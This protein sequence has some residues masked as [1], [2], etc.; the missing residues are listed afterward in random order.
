MCV[1]HFYGEANGFKGYH[2]NFQTPKPHILKISRKLCF[3]GL[4][5]LLW[6]DDNLKESLKI[7]TSC[8]WEIHQAI[9]FN[10]SHH[11]EP[12]EQGLKIIQNLDHITIYHLI[13]GNKLLVN[14]GV[15]KKHH[16]K[17]WFS[18]I[19]EWRNFPISCLDPWPCYWLVVFRPTPLKNDRVKVS[20][21][22][23]IPNS[24]GKILEIFQTTAQFFCFFSVNHRQVN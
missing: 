15:F 17:N 23:D 12:F 2:P 22:Y 1:I 20:W 14:M 13:C 7:F 19:S 16:P 8:R 21:E 10:T 4:I 18:P 5:L 9:F 11:L 3:L 6:I 24:N